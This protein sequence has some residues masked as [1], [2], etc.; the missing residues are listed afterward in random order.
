MNPGSGADFVTPCRVAMRRS[1]EAQIAY[2]SP[3]LPAFEVCVCRHWALFWLL[4]QAPLRAS[5]KCL[6]VFSINEY[7]ES[8]AWSSGM[9]I[10][11]VQFLSAI[12]GRARCM[13]PIKG[14]EEH[15]R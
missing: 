5:G 14:E 2:V 9:G 8:I 1:R 4:L 12:S 11:G 10:D 3:L 6:T 15:F 7:N 13:R